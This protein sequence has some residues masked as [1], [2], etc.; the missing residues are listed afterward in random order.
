MGEGEACFGCGSEV[1]DVEKYKR[2]VCGQGM[3]RGGQLCVHPDRKVLREK[4]TIYHHN[5]IIVIY[6]CD[7]SRKG[8]AMK[9]IELLHGSDHIIKKPEIK[10]GK[11]YNDYGRGFY[12]TRDPELAREWACK[13]NTDGVVNRYHIDV[14]GLNVL[15]LYDKEYSILH[16][17]ALLL[18]YRT[19]RISE[20]IAADARDYIIKEF[21]VDIESY[22]IVKGY[23]ADDSY[24][25]FAEAFVQNSL[26]L[27]G[28]D[29]ALRLGHLG[30]QVV[31]RSKEAFSRLEFV[32]CE[33]ADSRLYYPK[34]AQRDFKAREDY[35]Q[36]VRK[37]KAYKDDIFVLDILREEMKSNDER[38]QRIVSF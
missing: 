23:R 1:S 9:Q 29:M 35:R 13:N 5:D 26:P 6:H 27:R 36:E 4:L 31:L 32:G 12:C 38:I 14:E 33:P 3:G 30:E 17:I 16:W 10:L 25:A 21:A 28:L 8:E 20:G 11:P 2:L 18:K 37:S 19:F 34:F 15:N 24:F 7:D 22:D